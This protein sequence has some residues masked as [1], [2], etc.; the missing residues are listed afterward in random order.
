MAARMSDLHVKCYEPVERNHG[1]G[2]QYI[3][4]RFPIK[5]GISALDVMKRQSL[6]YNVLNAWEKVFKRPKS[7]AHG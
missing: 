2:P 5:D 4:H 3:R 6:E 1:N 7:P